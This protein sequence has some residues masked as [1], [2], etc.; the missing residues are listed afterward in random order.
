MI[1]PEPCGHWTANLP[2]NNFEHLVV[3]Q[4]YRVD[5][6]FQDFD[7]DIH[8][9]GEIWTF[10]GSNFSTHDNGLSLFVSLDGASEW[11]IRLQWHSSE[12]GPVIDDLGEYIVYQS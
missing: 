6:P 7:K 11:H 5:R 1:G 9:A 12:Q 3:G 10:L 8:E 4:R 2:S